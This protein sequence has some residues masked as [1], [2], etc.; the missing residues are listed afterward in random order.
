M[1]RAHILE[2]EVQ[3]PNGKIV[4]KRLSK[5]RDHPLRRRTDLVEEQ[6]APAPRASAAPSDIPTHYRTVSSPIIGVFY[7]ASSPQS[8]P[9]VKEGDVVDAGATICLVEAMKVM[10]EIKADC[11][12]RIIKILVE[13]TKPVT[14]NQPLFFMEP[15]V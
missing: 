11:R 10:N 13:N 1:V 14:K 6:H 9:F 15:A 3:T 2:L 5:E 7:R 4:L 8:A 12:C